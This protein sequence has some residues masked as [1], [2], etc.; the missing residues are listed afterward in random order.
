[1]R[2]IGFTGLIIISLSLIAASPSHS[3]ADLF[4]TDRASPLKPITTELSPSMKFRG[5]V[6]VSGRFLVVQHQYDKQAPYLQLIFYPDSRSAELLP[7]LEGDKPVKEVQISNPEK[8]VLMLLDPDALE[9][10]LKKELPSVTLRATAVIRA[11][12]IT[13]VCDQRWYLA[14]LV[15]ASTLQDVAGSPEKGRIGCG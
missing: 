7:R 3:Q 14:D 13:V 10:L 9:K 6:Q 2:S 8:A 15:S 11:Y 12:E 1:M 4:V 5:S